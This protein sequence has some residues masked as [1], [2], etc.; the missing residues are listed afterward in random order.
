MMVESMRDF[1]TKGKT[2]SA[3][4]FQPDMGNRFKNPWG[5]GDDIFIVRDAAVRL[6]L[7]T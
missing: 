2:M 3:E 6:G 5:Y 1:I 7:A 4:Y